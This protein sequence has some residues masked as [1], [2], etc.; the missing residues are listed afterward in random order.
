MTGQKNDF[1]LPRMSVWNKLE[2]N[3]LQD[4]EMLVKSYKEYLNNAKTEREAVSVT[5][6]MALMNGFV[7]IEEIEREH[8]KNPSTP[9]AGKKIY[10][11]NKDKNI[12]LAI[13]GSNPIT[14]GFSLIASHI[15]SPRLDLKPNPLIEKEK[16]ALLKTHYYGGIKKYHFA[17]IPLALHGVI[18]TKD[19]R[20]INLSLG[21]KED[22]PVFTVNDI[23]IHLSKKVQYERKTP[24][25]IKGE[26]LN[27]LF[28]SIPLPEG[29][30]KNRVKLMVLDILNVA[31]GITEEDFVSAE[32]EAVPAGKAR[33]VGMDRSMVGAYGQDDK[34]C[35]FC[36]L[37]ALFDINTPL[38][39]TSVVLMADK[40]EVGSEGNTSMQSNFFKLSIARLIALQEEYNGLKLMKSFMNSRAISADVSAA[41]N[42]NFP[43]VHDK[44]NAPRLGYGIAITKYTGKYGKHNTNDAN[45]EHLYSV[46]KI[47]NE[48]GIIWQS[49][50]LGK[51]DE[52][53][54]GTFAKFL[55]KL[56][57]DI[58]DS[59][60]AL[61]S[62]HS[63]FEVS[64]KADILMTKKAYKA[65][66]LS[67]K[68]KK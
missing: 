28:S 52:G 11:T 36:S 50:E 39:E 27:I 19:G 61:L 24:D 43:E 17:N 13:I 4:I 65:F 30:A 22:D 7:P 12:L 59:G 54:G 5:E 62:M 63:T 32:I 53:G 38:V 40:E 64:S 3:D 68:T 45:A 6:A 18:F 66:I 41:I 9:L 47:Y 48:A 35:A 23:L 31:Y 44:N 51:V 58:I 14:E 33:D 57:I 25:V 60:P 21:E 8:K 37:A 10:V 15:D 49:A 16:L 34:I 46:R 56:G 26:E 1:T 20:K 55:A 42:P 2:E 29:D 67:E